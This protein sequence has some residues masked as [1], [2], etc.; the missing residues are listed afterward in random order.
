V[1]EAFI[2]AIL[3]N[4]DDDTPR[5]IYADWL[6]DQ[7][8]CHYAEFIR[9]QVNLARTPH[10]HKHR[11]F[12]GPPNGC[13]ACRLKKRQSELLSNTE[14]DSFRLL[15]RDPGFGEHLPLRWWPVQ[16]EYVE[17]NPPLLFAAIEGEP[18][19]GFIEHLRI[20]SRDWSARAP[21][22]LANHPVARVTFPEAPLFWPE[23][24]HVGG[25]FPWRSRLWKQIKFAFDVPTEL[26]D[27][28]QPGPTYTPIGGSEI[29]VE[30]G[31]RLDLGDYV[32][33]DEF[34]RARRS[35]NGGIGYVVGTR[36]RGYRPGQEL[37]RVRLFTGEQWATALNL[38][39]DV[40]R[41][42]EDVC[43]GDGS[44]PDG[45]RIEWLTDARVTEGRPGQCVVQHWDRSDLF[46]LTPRRDRSYSYMDR[47]YHLTHLHREHFQR[48]VRPWRREVY[49]FYR[50][51]CD[52]CRLMQF[53]DLQRLPDYVD[54]Y[55]QWEATTGAAPPGPRS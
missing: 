37:V 11:D 19:R 10:N 25:D 23:F 17:P 6:D 16:Q 49:S 22:I 30:P 46:E 5:T 42:I 53:A 31:E 28:P 45:Y 47:W 20:D 2:R 54:E 12:G 26:L 39:V 40:A 15:G 41:Q 36:E 43:R 9:V 51:R 18:V 7:G 21:V 44:V 8:E 13:G 32:T 1:R 3:A 50:G 29:A 27:W 34:G 35:T 24:E 55:R 33:C 52:E 48:A 38:L 14:G 4:P